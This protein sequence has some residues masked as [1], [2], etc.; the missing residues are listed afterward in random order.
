MVFKDASFVGEHDST[1][2]IRRTT[3]TSKHFKRN[4]LVQNPL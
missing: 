2:Q 4:K 1:G 3:R